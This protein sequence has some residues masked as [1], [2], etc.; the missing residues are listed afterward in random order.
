MCW[1][2]GAMPSLSIVRLTFCE[3]PK[4]P[5]EDAA[6]RLIAGPSSAY[7]AGPPSLS[8][9]NSHAPNYLA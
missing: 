4:S 1:S 9:P 5:P 6:G 2:M 3:S 8:T 7:H